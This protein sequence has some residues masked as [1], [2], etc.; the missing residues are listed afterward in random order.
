VK[1][2]NAPLDTIKPCYVDVEVVGVIEDCHAISST[3]TLEE[4]QNQFLM[5]VYEGQR[6]RILAIADEIIEIQELSRC[7]EEQCDVGCRT[8]IKTLFKGDEIVSYIRVGVSTE[9]NVMETAVDL[10]G[11][12]VV[13]VKCRFGF[14]RRKSSL[15]LTAEAIDEI[16]HVSLL[17]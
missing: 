8:S 3:L 16:E 9:S 10:G 4:P 2:W 1:F 17:C 12:T 14:D 5:K 15:S 7:E 6:K 13:K 11:G